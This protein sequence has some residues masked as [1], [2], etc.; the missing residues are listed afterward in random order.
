MADSHLVNTIALLQRRSFQ[1]RSDEI[2]KAVLDKRPH[3]QFSLED[4]M[5]ADFRDFAPSIYFAMMREA[6]SRGLSF[7]FEPPIPV[8]PYE[9]DVWQ[10]E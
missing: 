2:V 4:L 3:D 6:N 1:D 7:P 10:T 8:R 5:E 9:E